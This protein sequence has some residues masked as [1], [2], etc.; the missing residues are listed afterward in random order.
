M[1][2][3]VLHGLRAAGVGNANEAAAGLFSAAYNA[4]ESL[5]PLLGGVLTGA[6]G[7]QA[8]SVAV[9]GATSLLLLAVLLAPHPQAPLYRLTG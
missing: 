1:R 4:G 2:A 3:A 9:A 6:L 7:F 8:A 5:G